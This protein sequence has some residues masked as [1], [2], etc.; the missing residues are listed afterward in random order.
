[1]HNLLLFLKNMFANTLDTTHNSEKL[2]TDIVPIYNQLLIL[3]NNSI[4][5]LQLP[6]NMTRPMWADIRNAL[7]EQDHVKQLTPIAN[8]IIALLNAERALQVLKTQYDK[9][10]ISSEKLQQNAAAIARELD[11]RLKL[12]GEKM[13]EI[14][15]DLAHTLQTM[16]NNIQSQQRYMFN[17]TRTTQNPIQK[18]FS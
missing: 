2:R 10:P 16:R 9:N 6:E 5:G 12:E 13:K 7:N 14:S 3:L 4:S 17:E 11:D 8:I 15:P 18:H 1:M